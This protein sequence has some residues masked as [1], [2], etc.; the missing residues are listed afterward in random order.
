VIGH[1]Q[2]SS[3]TDK[4]AA[5]I[6]T[7]LVKL[8]YFLKQYRRINGGPI[9]NNTGNFGVENARRDEVQAELTIGVNYRVPGIITTGKTYHHPGFF[10]KKVNYLSFAFI[11]PLSSDNGYRWHYYS[12]RF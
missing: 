7:S 11:S 1:N 10:R 8:G 6:D 9:A 5:G 3:A 4:Q 2:V 12:F